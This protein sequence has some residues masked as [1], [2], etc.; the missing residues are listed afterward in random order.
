MKNAIINAVV[1]WFMSALSGGSL[2][3]AIEQ[4]VYGIQID[5]PSRYPA[6]VAHPAVSTIVWGICTLL[7]LAGAIYESVL[8]QKGEA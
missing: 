8:E 1:W 3:W 7:V 6:W 2:I 4:W 5:I